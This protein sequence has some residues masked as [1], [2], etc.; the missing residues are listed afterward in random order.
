MTGHLLFKQMTFFQV[1]MK[2]GVWRFKADFGEFG[3]IWVAVPA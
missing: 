2:G 1:A 3:H